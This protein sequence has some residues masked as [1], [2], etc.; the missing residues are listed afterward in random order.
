MARD[1]ITKERAEELRG[2]VEGGFN[3]RDPKLIEELLADHLVDHNQLLGGVDLRQRM[4]RVLGAFGDAELTI[5]DYIF[6][7]NAVAWR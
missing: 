3:E 6:Q 4:A 2:R 7:G 5:D 1:E